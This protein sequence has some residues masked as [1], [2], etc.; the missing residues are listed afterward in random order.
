MRR[1]IAGSLLTVGLSLSLA[2]TAVAAPSADVTVTSVPPPGSVAAPLAT[3]SL[4]C[5][6]NSFSVTNASSDG[7][8]ITSVAIDLSPATLPDLIFDPIEGA[9]GGDVLGLSFDAGQIPAG[10]TAVAEFP[11]A[12]AKDDGFSQIAVTTTG[13]V[14]G[15]ELRFGVDVD[16][17]SAKGLASP[18]AGTESLAGAIAGAELHGAQVTVTFSDD[19]TLTAEFI[20]DLALGSAR[21]QVRPDPLAEP[22]LTLLSGEAGPGAVS[23]FTQ[24]I[25]LTGPVG[26]T[27]AVAVIEGSLDLGGGAGFDIDPFELNRFLATQSY[28]F[29]LD[30]KGTANVEVALGSQSG[31]INTI[32]AWLTG[33]AVKGPVA[34]PIVLTI[35]PNA[36]ETLGTNPTPPGTPQEPV[37]VVPGIENCSGFVLTPAAPG[38]P[39]KV[40]LS[41]KQLLINQRIGQTAIRR[42]NAVEAWLNDGIYGSDFC[43]ATLTSD[44]VGSG[45]AAGGAPLWVSRADPRKP[46]VEPAAKGSGKVELSARQLK[47]NQRIY[48]A[49]VLRAKALNKRLKNLTGGDVVDGTIDLGRFPDDVLVAPGVAAV[50]M[51]ASTTEVAGLTDVGGKFRLSAE[52]LRTNQKIAQRAVRDSNSLIG[53]LRR[54]LLGVNFKP[55]SITA[56]DLTVPPFRGGPPAS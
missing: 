7:E 41:A 23:S 27:G 28:D 50:E 53:K 33:G 15:A 45:L 16:P 12:S 26:A 6:N 52:Q 11:A 18:A 51:P 36:P 9:L 13:L 25:T 22:G 5:A 30:D 40:T 39:G 35:D 17:T 20:G 34:G 3:A 55:G 46:Q 38:K 21:A 43:G 49:A 4:C 56:K 29:T 31:G 10:G 37:F 8:E 19:S 42:L 32:T 54:G 14:V 1:T 47:I 44:V 48:R 24:T 2:A